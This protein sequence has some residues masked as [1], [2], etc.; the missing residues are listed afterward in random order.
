MPAKAGIQIFLVQNRT[1]A[2]IPACARM[3]EESPDFESTD[4]E[5][6]RLCAKVGEYG[7]TRESLLR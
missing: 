1:N 5:P 7:L 4:S 2:W 3:T 6:P